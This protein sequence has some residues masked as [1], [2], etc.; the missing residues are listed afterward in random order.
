M[1]ALHSRSAAL[2]AL[3]AACL[4]A[5][6]CTT[7]KQIVGFKD[8]VAQA[9][10]TA[11]IEGRIDTEGHSEGTLVVVLG[12]LIEGE[13]NPVGV[14]S[15]VRVNPGTYA[16][17]V[18]PGRYQVGA[19]EDLNRNGLLDP[20]ER[21]FRVRDSEILDVGPGEQASFDIL[22]A[23]G[24]T[25]EELTEPLDVLAIVERTPKEQREFS[26]WAFSVLGE[27]CEDLGNAKFGPE[28]G[29]RGLWE[30]MN[31]LNDEL[32]GIYF[33]EPYDPDRNPVLFVH[34]IS[35][36]P[37]EFSTLIEELDSERFQAWFY[38]YPSGFGLD[39]IS[40]HL[41]TLLSR[42]QIKHGFDELAI[43]AHSMGGLV[44]RGAI[45]KYED[46]TNRDDIGLF[47]SISTPWAGDVKAKGAEDAP[48]ELPASFKDMSPSSDYLRWVFYE[49]EVREIVR[50]LPGEVDYHMILS[51]RMSSSNDVANDGSVTVASQARVEAQEQALTIRAWDYGHVD[52]LHSREAVARVKLLLD[53]R[54]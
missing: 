39:A 22:L 25:L 24:A 21:A 26:L 10:A 44:S 52:I 51:F 5:S 33:L 14:D 9:R 3:L 8:Q 27:I 37:Q 34:G 17:A 43:I 49:D 42:L 6:G 54:F 35:G 40:N 50:L 20:N 28:A 13:E 46:Q 36:F 16:F 38:F 31:F 32:A 11:R 53:N 19:Y 12:R 1:T 18:T 23:I 2:A 48:I 30:P 4:A 7:M 15:Y 45:L 47:I 29:P 41:A